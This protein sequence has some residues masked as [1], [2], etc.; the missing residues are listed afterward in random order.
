MPKKDCHDRQGFEPG[1]KYSVVLR[2]VT[3]A[4]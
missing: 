1:P 4:P 3:V 2:F